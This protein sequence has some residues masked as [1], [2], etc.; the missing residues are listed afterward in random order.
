[1]TRMSAPLRTV[2]AI[3][4]LRGPRGGL[5]FVVVLECNHWM[6]SRTLGGER[7]PCVACFIENV[8]PVARD[9]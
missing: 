3:H 8:F 6:T 2:V 1:M 5:L 7:R 4:E 9:A